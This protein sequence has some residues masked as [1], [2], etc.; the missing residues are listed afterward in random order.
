MTVCNW[1]NNRGPAIRMIPKIIQFLGYDPINKQFNT[2]GEKIK[3]YRRKR[4]LS[5]KKLARILRIDPT[6]LARWERGE[7]APGAG[8]HRRLHS[9]LSTLSGDSTV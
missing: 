7:G 8:L 1:E 4:G 5:I 6:T 2:F 9:F 3:A